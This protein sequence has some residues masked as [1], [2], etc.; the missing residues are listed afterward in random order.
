[1]RCPCHD[2]L[3]IASSEADPLQKQTHSR[4]KS[5]F[6]YVQSLTNI[7]RDDLNAFTSA[8]FEGC[9]IEISD[10]SKSRHIV[11]VVYGPH[12]HDINNFMTSF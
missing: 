12:G 11:N 1:M 7:K 9:F 8:D 2:L 3:I 5:C 10:N 6:V 4:W